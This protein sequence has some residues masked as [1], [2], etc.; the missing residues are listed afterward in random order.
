MYKV[1]DQR[2]NDERE[3]IVSNPYIPVGM[4]LHSYR[5][6]PKS[7][8]MHGQCEHVGQP[9]KYLQRHISA[10]LDGLGGEIGGPGPETGTM[11]LSGI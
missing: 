7:S 4:E 3:M 9:G 8:A 5:Y 6:T 10:C 2:T 11:P 1:N